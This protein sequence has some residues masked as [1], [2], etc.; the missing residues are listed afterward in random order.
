[1]SCVGLLVEQDACH[2]DF[3]WTVWLAVLVLV[4]APKGK[5]VVP[6]EGML[7]AWD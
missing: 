4:R 2:G 3:G 6:L 5:L 7:C 1:M